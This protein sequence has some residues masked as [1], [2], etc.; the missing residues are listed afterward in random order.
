M[1]AV[2]KRSGKRHLIHPDGLATYCGRIIYAKNWLRTGARIC[3]CHRCLQARMA[4]YGRRM[5]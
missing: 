1:I 3:D 4:W 5:A 2:Q